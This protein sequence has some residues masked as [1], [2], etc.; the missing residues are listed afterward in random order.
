LLKIRYKKEIME[1]EKGTKVKDIFKDEIDKSNYLACKFNNEVKSL[2]FELESDGEIRFITYNDRDG[3]RIYNRGIIYIMS[4]ALSELYPKAL[5]TINYQLTGAMFCEIEN[6]KITEEIIN[7]LKNKMIEITNK[8]LEIRKVTMSTEEAEKFYEKEK[9]LKGIVQLDTKVKNGVSLYFCEDYYNY[10][11]G[12]MP[13]STGIIKTYDVERYKE[14][15]LVRFPDKEDQ[16]I[17]KEHKDSKKLYKTLQEY[18]DIHKVLGINTLYKLNNKINCG[19]IN[20]NIL[21]AESLHEKKIAEIADKIAQRNDVKVV[22]IA[23]PSSGAFTEVMVIV[24]SALISGLS[25]EVTV[26]TAVPAF[27]AVTRPF[28]STVATDS[29]EDVHSQSFT[30]ALSGV[31]VATS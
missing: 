31:T 1:I 24:H 20:D 21:L 30:V 19:E 4:K 18:E 27:F 15:F 26:I 6:M 16:N 28:S 5:L 17:I 23:G 10:F 25:F 11:Y 7:N 2:D 8:D 29:S 9:S 3:K 12:V 14:G 13:I 22:L